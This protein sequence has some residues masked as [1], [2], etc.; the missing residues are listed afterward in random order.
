MTNDS[1][2]APRDLTPD[3]EAVLQEILGYLNFSS[4][5]PDAGFQKNLNRV[6]E[7]LTALSWRE[8]QSHLL[9]RLDEL[10]RTSPTFADSTQARAV[11]DLV[12]DHLWPAYR[13]FHA[14][15]LFHLTDEELQQPFFLARLFEAVLA[16]EPPWDEIERIIAGS[17]DQL[18]GFL[19]FRPVAVLE[20]DQKMQPYSHERT[21]P[22]PIYLRGAGI[23]AGKYQEL[24]RRTLEFIEATPPEILQSAHFDLS[25]LE[26][27]S[28]DMRAHDHTHPVNKRTNY[29]FG[30]WDP[31]L[32]DTQGYYQRF[33]I[34]KIIL[35]SLVDWIEKNQSDQPEEVLYDASAVL[36]GTMLMAS[37]ISGSGP[38][39]HSSDVT[40][41]SLL[42]QV[43]RQRDAFYAR[44]LEAVEGP[45][46]QRL[47]QQNKLTQ[48]P[49][50]HVRQGLNLYLARYGA[51]QMQHRHLALIYAH[52]GFANASREQS[53][54]I[55]SASVRFE[56]EIQ[57]RLTDV[58]RHLERGQ[59]PAAVGLIDEVEDLLQRGIHCGALVDPWNILGF[60]G[61]FPLFASRE[62]SI[63]DQRVE[64]L[65]EIM[66]RIFA[67]YSRALGES[68]AQGK[69]E[70]TEQLSGRFL[71]LADYWD[72]FATHV[73]ED[74]PEVLGRAS[75]ES[76][77]HVSRALAEWSAA[78]E[79]A[80]D[81]SFWRQH[82]ERFQSAESYALVV[83]C[84]LEKG[85]HVA[86]MG[87]LMQWLSRVEEV[88]VDSG[89]HS[90]NSSLLEWIYRVTRSA[91][92][93][94][95]AT[96]IWPTL[97]KLF[98]YLEA[99]AGE[100]WEVPSLEEAGGA[101]PVTAE[102]PMLP[103][104]G[105]RDP[106]FLD[107]EEEDWEDQLYQ[108]A[109]DDVVFKDS[110]LDGHDGETLDG[111]STSET[112][113]FE[114]I[115]R[116]LEPRLK[117]VMTLAQLWQIAIGALGA[118]AAKATGDADADDAAA[119]DAANDD[120][121][122][123]IA[124]W[125]RKVTELQDD[126]MQL[127]NAVWSYEIA[128]PSGDHDSNVE[129]DLHLQTKFY[130]LHNI[131]ATHVNCRIADRSL[132]SCLSI[133]QPDSPLSDDDK[134]MVQV[135]RGILNRDIEETR[136]RLPG[137][138]QRMSRKPLLYVP[139]DNGGHPQQILAAR[140]VQTDIRF[141]LTQL[142]R[143]GMLRETWHI[144][145]TAHRM[146][147]ASRP[148]ELAVT[149]F[150]RI[151]RTALRNS[152]ECILRSS[153]SWKS[154]KSSDA[155][156][157]KIVGDVVERYLDQWLRHSRTMRLSTVEGFEHDL[158]WEDVKGFITT[159]GA[160]LFHAKMLTLG[161]VRAILHNGIE[162]FLDYLFE[163][164]DPLHRISLLED[165]ESGV[166]D[167]EHV[168]DSLEMIYGSVVDKF[169]RFLEYNTT[170]T[171]S[172]Y[173]EM[174]YYLLDFLRVEA[175]YDRD[176]W[177]FVPLGIAHKVLSQSERTDAVRIW[178]GVFKA[179]SQEL[180]DRHVR[181]LRDL[182]MSCGI[183]LPSISDRINERFIQP[184]AVNRILAL[185]PR[186]MDD[187]RADRLP[188]ESFESLRAEVD[189]YLNHT[190][191]SGIEV[192]GWLQKFEKEVARLESTTAGTLRK[193]DFDV[194]APAV[195]IS[196]KDLREQLAAWNQPLG[197]KKTAAKSPK[198]KR[199]KKKK[200]TDG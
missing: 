112:T 91:E 67:A 102:E 25:R 109:Y 197:T 133:D 169:D 146:E 2:S 96:D 59:L 9:G 24:I 57:W 81:I 141:L 64:S 35:D 129:Y 188:S 66:E 100:F 74:L 178:E 32:I 98:D 170:T 8:L 37:A 115:A 196:P 183:H 39:T 49:F 47:D 58:H 158:I 177:N 114:L 15:L 19:G 56:C 62:D 48:Q 113:E 76:A 140:T 108:A 89:P 160:E 192:P 179:K 198:K 128:T 166:V 126:L 3:D 107:Q 125:Q 154:G 110:A 148:G 105:R 30:E 63:P 18:N 165:L 101:G 33:L 41:T 189:D 92:Q 73:V 156:L 60:Q 43:A 16:Q 99:N 155:E 50:G 53:S 1:H 135:Y 168:V 119:N 14:D 55:P 82:V 90:I 162:W 199:T 78:G 34:R 36:C 40:L 27:L 10:E 132:L 87:L 127:L 95:S 94:D 22:V 4:G 194:K 152:L 17:L 21:C 84:L 171:Q 6:F 118:D 13:Q 5:K 161:N 42:P 70:L 182:E 121:R 163:N 20:N 65:L 111:G 38:D 46:A 159:Y 175:A 51:R 31:H 134:Q 157:V 86:A 79:A 117:F 174:F 80:G 144:L 200:R 186:A 7:R 11:I 23:A 138:L 191:G 187:A 136:L 106:D 180:A 12:F 71:K 68:A 145:R 93:A 193:G 83:D 149:E 85:D 124:G 167:V 72:K 181:E 52:M 190:S 28:L 164:E 104:S 150:D 147:R 153:E 137:L 176:A 45:R 75:W 172:D 26:E 123:T 131:I 122:E 151:F 116:A 139:L 88:G 185:I 97:R 173:G 29:M 61:Q 69:N 44:L 143:L 195:S 142:P 77:N 103:G 184:L 130:M 54:I 120:R